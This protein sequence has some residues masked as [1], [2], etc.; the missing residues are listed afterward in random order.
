MESPLDPSS[1]MGKDNDFNLVDGLY[2]VTNFYNIILSIKE[3]MSAFF[4]F[5]HSLHDCF[6]GILLAAFCFGVP[7]LA[8]RSRKLPWRGISP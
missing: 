1:P 4:F 5:I 2:L 6:N 3:S 8:A 7:V